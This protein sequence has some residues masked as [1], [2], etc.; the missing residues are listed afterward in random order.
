M[1]VRPQVAFQRRWVF[2][3]RGEYLPCLGSFPWR[4]QLSRLAQRREWWSFRWGSWR[5]FA[6]HLWVWGPSGE[7]TLSGC[8]SQT[9]SVRPQ[10]AFQRRWVFADQEE[11]LPCPG[12]FLWQFRSSLRARHRE[13]WSFRWGSWRK[14][15]LRC[16]L[17]M[18]SWTVWC[19]LCD[20][21]WSFLILNQKIPELISR[22]IA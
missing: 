5:K 14:S 16:F 10:V 20:S 1:S 4:F 2:A 6:F 9:M 19:N 8:C 15:A 13:W 22:F 18:N 7:W 3:D 12:S 17:I 11:F 21:F